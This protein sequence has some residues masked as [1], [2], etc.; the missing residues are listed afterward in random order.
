[1]GDIPPPELYPVS[2]RR[3]IE[4]MHRSL[5][6]L[7]EPPA[8]S[9]RASGPREQGNRT[10]HELSRI[11]RGVHAHGLAQDP[12]SELGAGAF[13]RGRGVLGFLMLFSVAGGSMTP[14]V[15]PQM[16]RFGLG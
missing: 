10:G 15:E 14:W 6:I 8:P 4:E 1:V 11:Q 5:P 13:A 3:D 7:E 9:G 16:Q 2:Q 12:A